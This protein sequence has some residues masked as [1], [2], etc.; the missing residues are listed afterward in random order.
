MGPQANW[1]GVLIKRGN[2]G[3]QRHLGCVC[4]EER[5]CENSVR[6]WPF[7]RQGERPQTETDVPTL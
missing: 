3:A 6:R 4:T 1:T 7:A 2:L 5:P